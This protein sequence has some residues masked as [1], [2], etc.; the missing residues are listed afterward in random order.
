LALPEK[1]RREIQNVAFVVERRPGAR[2]GR[3]PAR[4]P[5]GGAR[6]GD[7]L[8]GLY[9]GLPRTVWGRE[10]SGKLPDKITIFQEPIERLASWPEEIP[11]MVRHT[12]WHEIGHYL[13][14]DDRRLRALERKWKRQPPGATADP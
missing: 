11:E 5:A 3:R 4:G 9:E 1:I 7:F 12:V 8:L 2:S 10:Y 13:G 6:S 14:F